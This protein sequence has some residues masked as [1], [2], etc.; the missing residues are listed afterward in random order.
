[1]Q[2][3]IASPLINIAR[4][5]GW[6]S[7]ETQQAAERLAAA[8]RVELDVKVAGVKELQIVTIGA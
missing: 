5:L 2:N 7:T 3:V 1:V 6:K 8:G 4:L